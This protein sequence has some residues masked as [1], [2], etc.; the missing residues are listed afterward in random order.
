[1]NKQLYFPQNQPFLFLC[2]LLLV[3]AIFVI[4]LILYSGI[5]LGPDEAQYWTWS[6][7]LSLGYYSKPPGI[8]WQIWLGSTLLGNN[9]LGVRIFSVVLGTALSLSVYFLAIFSGTKSQTAFWAGLVMAFSPLGTM[10]S[11]LAITDGGMV[12]C[13]TFA[14]LWMVKTLQE[15]AEPRYYL[16]GIILLCGALFKWPIYL[17]WVLVLVTGIFSSKFFN[18]QLLIGILISLFGLIPS[19]IWNSGHDWVTFRH[20]FSTVKGGHGKE[21]GVTQLL[22]G[23]FWEFLGGQAAL[24]S[25]IF[26]VLLI[27]SFVFLV[28]HYRRISSP[29]IFC[30]A[31]TLLLL[32][33]FV[34]ASCFQKI[35]GNWSSFIYPAGIVFLCWVICEQILKSQVWLKLGLALSIIL[36]IF[37]FSI[38]SVQSHSIL[39]RYPIP[40]KINPFRHNVG[41]ERLKEELN[42]I[43]YDPQQHFLFGDKYQ[44]SSILSFYSPEQ[45]RAYFLNLQGIRKNQFSFWPSMAQ[46]QKGKTG[47]FVLAENS[48][49]L[50]RGLSDRISSYQKILEDYFQKV[51]FLGVKSLFES[52]GKM[53]K[54]ALIYR[55]ENYNGREPAE[56][57]LY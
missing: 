13:W 35:Q 31:S 22:S 53:A 10:A 41:W 30:G 29:L 6:R 20:V 50:E 34:I 12:L 43:G 54:G 39:S 8:A 16:L 11:L 3:K 4:A 55:C 57:E 24:L 23:N 27:F 33:L 36:L 18:K 44:M 7:D 51:E 40:Y 56:P 19:V 25:P 47:F 2:F 26:F 42:A 28:K 1:M 9:E 38:P 49:H 14:C 37:V 48:P 45:K 32:I 15:D 5:G 46:E 21:I 17:F 52:Y